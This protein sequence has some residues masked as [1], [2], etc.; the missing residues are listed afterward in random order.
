MAPS[1]WPPRDK[2]SDT[3]AHRCREP[4]EAGIA[5]TPGGWVVKD[6][7]SVVGSGLPARE[8]TYCAVP[9]ISQRSL[10]GAAAAL[11]ARSYSGQ[12]RWWSCGDGRNALGHVRR[13]LRA[14]ALHGAV[15]EP[16]AKP[17]PAV[18]SSYMELRR[19]APAGMSCQL[20]ALLHPIYGTLPWRGSRQ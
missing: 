17:A 20:G 5:V 6:S 10:V 12:R 11:G 1:A 19:S 15:P 13:H 4:L 7:R 2:M 14:G 3:V 16:G 8:G 9:T 18:P